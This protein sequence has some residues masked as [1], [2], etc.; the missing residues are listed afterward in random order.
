M[1][2]AGL[3][4]KTSDQ[5]YNEAIP[6][7]VRMRP[8]AILVE[9]S[10]HDAVPGFLANGLQTHGYTMRKIVDA[11]RAK[12]PGIHIT[13]Q[14]MSPQSTSGSVRPDLGLF[15]D[16]DREV[17]LEKRCNLLDHNPAWIS[18]AGGVPPNQ[19]VFPT[20]GLWTFQNDG[21]HP[22]EGKVDTILL[23][24]LVSYY[25]AVIDNILLIVGQYKQCTSSIPFSDSLTVWGATSPITYSI[26]SGSLPPG[27]SLNTATGVISG[28]STSLGSYSFTLQAVDSKGLIGALATSIAVLNQPTPTYRS[29]AVSTGSNSAPKP[30]GIAVGDLVF[31]VASYDAG[32]TLTTLN[33]SG[34]TA[35]NSSIMAW[36]LSHNYRSVVFW[37]V[38]TAQDLVGT[39]GSNVSTYWDVI[40][41]APG[42]ADRI[43]L[44]QAV[45][46]TTG[47]SS[48]TFTPL[49]KSAT[50]GG[51]LLFVVDRDDTNSTYNFPAGW[52]V[53]QT[54]QSAT[55]FWTKLGDRLAGTYVDGDTISV[56]GLIGANGYAEI[57]WLF[58]LDVA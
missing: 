7:L 50:H 12:L 48:L 39:W 2:D 42:G 35:W 53:R 34:G 51:L 13:I 22:L 23:P 26:V 11:F 1:I 18:A 41:Y 27:L 16:S 28:T 20:D 38:L 36:S 10:M 4:G 29:K 24:R 57:G 43:T 32:N 55:Y 8:D 9:F 52:V 14:T 56:T 17:A 31:A 37:K 40:A 3:S 30:A 15:Y 58:E 5:V 45:Q 47:Q 44:R 6:R 46:N 21:V 25:R 49:A 33:T 19:F 54:A